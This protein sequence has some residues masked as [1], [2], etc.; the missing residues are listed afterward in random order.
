[1]V[2]TCR[3]CNALVL[4]KEMSIDRLPEIPFDLYEVDKCMIKNHKG[5]NFYFRE[6]RT[7]QTSI[8]IFCRNFI[9][10]E[11]K[12]YIEDFAKIS[13]TY[14]KNNEVKIILIASAYHTNL[15]AFCVETKFVHEVY[16][17]VSLAIH[18]K[19]QLFPQIVDGGGS[20]LRRNPHLK[21]NSFIRFLLSTKRASERSTKGHGSMFQQGGQVVIDSDGKVLFF[22]RDR[23]NTDQT[24]INILLSACG[25]NKSFDSFKSHQSKPNIFNDL[26]RRNTKTMDFV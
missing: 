12:D 23:H 22:H 10:Q 11:T 4:P 25:L 21:N 26:R 6:V 3:E 8:I 2:C 17:D 1:M 14:L 24:P 13:P 9:D 20:K 15:A 5:K 7:N 18:K 19:A 16:T